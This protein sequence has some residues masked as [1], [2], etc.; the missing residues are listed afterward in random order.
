MRNS[1]TNKRDVNF[2]QSPLFVGDFSEKSNGNP[3]PSS[4]V[5]MSS[6]EAQLSTDPAQLKV[7]R[8]QRKCGISRHLG[9]LEQLMAEE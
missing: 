9:T 2:N 1:G 7:V 5:A 8:R 6:T 4:S 3:G